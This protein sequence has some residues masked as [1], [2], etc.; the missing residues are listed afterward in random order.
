MIRHSLVSILLPFALLTGA[1]GDGSDGG[2]WQHREKMRFQA[3]EAHQGVAVDDQHFY[4]I[5]NRAIGKY[6]K[7]TG[8]RVAGWEDT[9]DGR[10]RHLN[11]GVVLDGRLYCAHS[12]FP[13]LPEESSIEIWDA[14][15]MR[16]LDSHR[17]EKPPGSLTWVDQRDGKWFA[18]FARYR[19]SSDPALS[20]VMSFDE[21]WRPL[22]TWT[23]PAA[24]I[25]R[26][27]DYSSS[28]GAFGPDGNLFVSGH[29]ATELYVLALAEGG[30]EMTLL[31]TVTIS[32]AGQ[33]FAW[34]RSAG[35]EGE[36]YFIHRKSREVI[37]SSLR[38]TP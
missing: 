6:R 38:K 17:F 10:L 8:A 7:D 13:A 16:H 22:E 35:R 23:F 33:A 3:A 4:A 27:G 28:G 18:C 26:F 12:N 30:G 34:D 15:T 2:R 19:S 37:L 31:G 9:S 25:V 24:V 21:K 20:R 14:A 36:V 1:R 32:A 5:T 29:D 11:A